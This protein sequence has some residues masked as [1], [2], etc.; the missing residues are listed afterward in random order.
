MDILKETLHL[1]TLPTS[2]VPVINW[3]F[4]LAVILTLIIVNNERLQKLT[5]NKLSI[6]K[7]VKGILSGVFKTMQLGEGIEPWSFN[8]KIKKFWPIF[9]A[10]P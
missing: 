9:L 1:V 3:L 10:A 4:A 6:E 7:I 5:K 2:V 8:R